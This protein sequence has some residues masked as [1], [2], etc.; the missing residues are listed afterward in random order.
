MGRPAALTAL[1]LLVGS[2]LASAAGPQEATPTTRG[3]EPRQRPPG[4]RRA[5]DGLAGFTSRSTLTFPQLPDA[6]FQLEAT[7]VFPGRARWVIERLPDEGEGAPDRRARTLRFRYGEALWT[8]EPGRVASRAFEG[9]ELRLA[10]LQL[11]LRR[12]ATTWPA[13]LAWSEEGPRRTLELTGLGKLEAELDSAGRPTRLVARD[14]DGTERERLDA[15]R[16][17]TPAEEGARS[18]PASWELHAGGR[19]VW[20]ETFEAVEPAA[21]VSELLFLPPDRQGT[22]ARVSLP[23]TGPQRV[24]L[25]EAAIH[26]RPLSESERATWATALA[27]ARKELA[28]AVEGLGDTVSPRPTFELDD[29]GRPLALELALTGLPESLPDGWSRRPAGP[30]W[31]AVLVGTDGLAPGLRAL[32]AALGEDEPSGPARLVVQLTPSGAGLTQLLQPVSP[33]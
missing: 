8:I 19:L 2:G 32:E 29:E 1:L 7:Y 11:A 6:R 5:V 22:G 24:E 17:R 14:P 31:R 15:V 3:E 13:G 30:A 9:E 10:R 20:R 12:I 27:A 33:R 25:P 21:K 28:R 4:R 16:W 23:S 18:W 26:R